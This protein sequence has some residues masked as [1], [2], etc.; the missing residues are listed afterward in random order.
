MAIKV[1]LAMSDYH[2]YS[3]YVREILTRALHGWIESDRTDDVELSE[4][5]P[6]VPFSRSWAVAFLNINPT[7]ELQCPTATVEH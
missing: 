3:A 4:I 6:A 5:N 1:L 7:I 2:C